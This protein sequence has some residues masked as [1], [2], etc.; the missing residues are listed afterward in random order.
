MTVRAVHWHEG[1]FLRPHQL[2]AAQ[3]YLL[4]VDQLSAKWDLH[5]NWG[6][7]S[8]DIDREA[9]GNHRLVIR[10]LE[11]RLRDG[12]LVAI[13]EDTA[14]PSL[15]LQPAL[16]ENPTVMAYLALPVMRI[17]RANVAAPGSVDGGRYQVDS[18]EIEDENTGQNPQPV[19]IRIPNVRV[20]LSTQDMAGYETM[21]IARIEKSMAADTA[22]QIDGSY[23]PPALA[24]DAW[25]SLRVDILQTIYDRI[26]RKIEL[27]AGQVMSRGIAVES[28]AAADALIITQLRALNESYALLGILA[29]AQGVHPLDAYLELCRL[30]GQLAIFGDTHR[31]PELPKYDHDDLGGCFYQVKKYLDALLDKIIEPEYKQRPFEGAGL[32]MQVPLEPAWLEPAWQMYVGVKSP[33]PVDECV[34]LLTKSGQLDMKIGSSDRV[35]RIYQLGQA[36]LKFTHSPQPPRALPVIKDLIYFQVSRES[37]QEEWQNVQKSLTLAIR[38]N[39]TRIAGNIQ[40]QRTLTIRT[41]GQTTTLDFT[42]FVVKT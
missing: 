25:P 14:L 19:Q 26:G 22:P 30:V 39:E 18:Q 27:L 41:A 6:L 35:D 32:R 4:H 11:A 40:G 38:L 8:I 15:D 31:P 12:T 3:R 16:Q 17:G 5:Y 7:R 34:K 29:F 24:C 42:L 2:Q 36:G 10:R 23:I 13:P 33:L 9:L 1:M 21:P 20:L 28:H 37:Q